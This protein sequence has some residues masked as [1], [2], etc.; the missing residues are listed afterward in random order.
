MSEV[1]AMFNAEWAANA[2]QGTN[3][4]SASDANSVRKSS[5]DKMADQ[6]PSKRQREDEGS[7]SRNDNDRKR[8][9]SARQQAHDTERAQD[10]ASP[11]SPASS[12]SSLSSTLYGGLIIRD[13]TFKEPTAPFNARDAGQYYEPDVIPD[14]PTSSSS[15]GSREFRDFEA[16]SRKHLP[17]VVEADLQATIS[18]EFAPVEEALRALLGDIVRRSLSTVSKSF[19]RL[20]GKETSDTDVSSSFEAA[21]KSAVIEDDGS[22]PTMFMPSGSGI[23]AYFQEPSLLDHSLEQNPRVNEFSCHNYLQDL[24]ESQSSDSGYNSHPSKCAC[25]CH[26]EIDNDPRIESQ[27]P[28]GESKGKAAM[29]ST[30]EPCHHCICYQQLDLDFG[31]VE[32][33]TDIFPSLF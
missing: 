21:V 8:K 23:Q 18:K 32:F 29:T 12:E 5:S 9:G 30:A 28:E 24:G 27:H 7:P 19:Q 17:Q 33:D 3:S 22:A 20:Q 26:E 15:P 6:K 4:G 13:N 10:P 31:L 2:K 11:Q 16:Y 25:S 1:Y 14:E